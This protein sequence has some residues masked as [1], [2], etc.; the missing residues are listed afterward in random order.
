MDF[1]CNARHTECNELATRWFKLKTRIAYRCEEHKDLVVSTIYDAGFIP[2]NKQEA[3]LFLER[4]EKEIDQNLIKT[5]I[6]NVDK[7]NEIIDMISVEIFSCTPSRYKKF[8]K[9]LKE[10]ALPDDIV[11]IERIYITKNKFMQLKSLDF[12]TTVENEIMKCEKCREVAQRNK[13]YLP[14]KKHME[15]AHQNILEDYNLWLKIRELESFDESNER[16]KFSDK[17]KEKFNKQV[18]EMNITVQDF[19]E[20]AVENDNEIQLVTNALKDV[21]RLDA[22]DTG[23]ALLISAR[24]NMQ[25]GCETC[26]TLSDEVMKNPVI[27]EKRHYYELDQHFLDSHPNT[28]ETIVANYSEEA[29]DEHNLL[30]NYVRGLSGLKA[31]VK[32][33]RVKEYLTNREHFLINKVNSAKKSLQSKKSYVSWDGFKEYIKPLRIYSKT[34]WITHTKTKDFPENI[35]IKPQIY[36]Q[37]TTYPDVFGYVQKI[38]RESL[39][40]EKLKEILTNFGDRWLDYR[41]YP[42]AYLMKW[43]S[44]MGLF[45]VHDPFFKNLFKNFIE[46]RNDPQGIVALRYWVSTM[47]F[48]KEFGDFTLHQKKKETKE[49]Y[50]DR[51]MTKL[52]DVRK[53]QL[54]DFAKPVGM[55]AIFSNTTHVIPFKDEDPKFYWTQVKFRVRQMFEQLFEDDKFQ[56]EFQRIEK[57]KTGLNEFHDDILNEFWTEWNQ[58]EK[59]DYCKQEYTYPHKPMLIQRYIANK[60]KQSNGFFSMS[61]TGTGKT[62]QEIISAVANNSVCCLAIVPNAIVEQ[63]ARNIKQFY[64]NCYV[65]TV[66]ETRQI[67]ADFFRRRKSL[68]NKK[69]LTNFYVVNYDLFRSKQAGEKF[70]QR[71]KDLTI[72]SEIPHIDF[73][74]LDE[75]HFIKISSR[76]EDIDSEKQ[77][78]SNRRKNVEMVIDY[79][80]QRDRKLKVLM[81]TATPLVNNI[82]E[83]KSQLEM[84]TGTK[85]NFSTHAYIKNAIT[86]YVEFIPYSLAYVKD[87]KITQRGKDTPIVV[88]GFL[89]EHLTEQQKMELT[90]LEL[91][92]IATKYR[93][94]KMLELIRKT[95]DSVV[96]YTDYRTGVEDQIAKALT[97][98]G[99]KIGYFTGEDKQGLEP[100]K[101]KELDVL[102]ASRPFAV[103]VDEVQYNCNTII[104]NG[105]V[106]TWAQFE[107][108]VGRIVRIGQK[109]NFVDIHMIFARLDGYEYDE[110]IKYN[111]IL[112]KKALGDCIRDGTIPEQLGLGSVDKDRKKAIS[113]MIENGK[114]G[115]PNKEEVEK[116]LQESAMQELETKTEQVSEEMKGVEQNG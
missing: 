83:A 20:Y 22:T 74:I 63:V 99:Y 54:L 5:G 31:D 79:L 41:M 21:F 25:E 111:R 58:I 51:Q 88:D 100:F 115:F 62:G 49:D 9:L 108:I 12:P 8:V 38:R 66:R 34:D 33:E 39:T 91:E 90:Y 75:S 36:A 98:A 27:E 10:Y 13:S 81:A 116:H 69:P 26:K 80:R 42:D 16:I 89:P 77:K 40:I 28:Y 57:E 92:Q 67:P 24:K 107:Q 65:K 46:W 32:L 19:I 102:I 86:C 113:Q 4:M 48:E 105:L 95:N 97:D 59:M 61:S 76:P 50:L 55:D 3:I 30:R 7:Y 109:S 114:S 78:I 11:G 82:Q 1:F 84:V 44:S 70:I 94:P 72:G 60:M 101:R 56:K 2:E 53:T 103:G 96:I 37:F 45:S 23:V 52:E 43:F 6:K 71:I 14:F 35:P 110:K 17:Q 68:Q 29:R 64:Y 15:E 73:V 106:W 104:L 93:I 85:F 87:Y 47:D 112:A 18:H